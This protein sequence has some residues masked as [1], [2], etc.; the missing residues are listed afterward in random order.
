M[1]AFVRWLRSGIR[2]LLCRTLLWILA[3]LAVAA[4]IN[5]IGIR[6]VGDVA[7]WNLWLREHAA[8][9]AAWRLCVYGATVYGWWQLREGLRRREPGPEITRRLR[10][11]EIAAMM[12]VLAVEGAVYLQSFFLEKIR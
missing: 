6:I 5:V 1:V 3:L 2:R 7:S 4:A 12:T 9:F 11:M 10:R 8:W